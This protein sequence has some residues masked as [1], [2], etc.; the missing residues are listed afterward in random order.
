MLVRQRMTPEP[1]V[2]SADAPL[3]EA[4]QKMQAGGFR[5]LPVLSDGKLVG[6]VTDSDLRAHGD[7]PEGAKVGS[8]M[9]APVLTIRSSATVEEAAQLLIRHKIGGLPVVDDGKVVG[10]LTAV[11]ILKA[12]VDVM[13]ASQPASAR[14]DFVLEGE[15]HGLTEASRI[16]S[17]EGG[18]ILGVGTYREKLGENPVCYLRVVGGDPEKIAQALR[19]GGFDVLGVHALAD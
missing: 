2:I 17:G 3:S 4:R 5:R 6:I 14:I 9:R 10:I 15:E 16:V 8:V 18:E 7:A 12:F 19:A 13:G 11:D 1:V